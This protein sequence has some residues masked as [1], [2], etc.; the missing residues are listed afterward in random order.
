MNEKRALVPYI[1]VKIRETIILPLARNSLEEPVSPAAAVRKNRAVR[2]TSRPFIRVA[3]QLH[4]QL[5]SWINNR[6][7]KTCDQGRLEPSSRAV[8]KTVLLFNNYQRGS[9]P[10]VQNWG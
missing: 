10:G 8:F 6:S 3:G 9:I 5:A 2:G 4:R 1:V 7:Q